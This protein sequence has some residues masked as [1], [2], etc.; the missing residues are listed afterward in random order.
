MTLA[1]VFPLTT[2]LAFPTPVSYVFALA[3]PIKSLTYFPE[4]FVVQRIG[5]LSYDQRVL[6]IVCEKG[7]ATVQRAPVWD[8]LTCH[9]FGRCP[10]PFLVP[11]L[12]GLVSISAILDWVLTFDVFP[13][14]C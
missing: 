14:C 5:I 13:L 2:F 9:P 8:C 10:D 12:I 11:P 3:W 1:S 6:P 7:P 4:V